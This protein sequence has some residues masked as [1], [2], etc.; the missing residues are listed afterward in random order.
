[1]SVSRSSIGDYL[2]C[3]GLLFRRL[4]FPIV[5][6][7]GTACHVAQIVNIM[8]WCNMSYA[9]CWRACVMDWCDSQKRQGRLSWWRARVQ[10]GCATSSCST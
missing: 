8:P 1:M 3:L 7:D 9:R 2:T 10:G 6:V 5:T 4:A